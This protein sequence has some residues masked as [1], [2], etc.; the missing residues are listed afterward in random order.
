MPTWARWFLAATAALTAPVVSAGDEPPQAQTPPVAPTAPAINPLA[1]RLG[2]T[3]TIEL[4]GR[5]DVDAVTATQSSA[6]KALLGDLENAYGFRRA[7]LGA[8]GTVGTSARWVA[9]A[10]FA[11]GGAR[12]RG[13]FGA[14]RPGAIPAGRGLEFLFRRPGL[15]LGRHLAR[16]DPLEHGQPP[17]ADALVGEVRREL[18]HAEV[19]LRL[20]PA[21]S[22]LARLRPADQPDLRHRRVAGP[23]RPLPQARE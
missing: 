22:R 14:P 16:L 8:Q 20:R 7:R 15:R 2:L 6:S 10:D 18:V 11:G 1:E 9:E 21:G 12:P 5:L 13:G 17:S 4:R 23:R 3:P 19:A